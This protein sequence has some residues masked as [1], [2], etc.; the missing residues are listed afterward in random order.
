MVVLTKDI[1]REFSNHF[2]DHMKGEDFMFFFYDLFTIGSAYIV[3]GYFR[4]FL[5]KQHSRDID[6]ITDIADEQLIDIL[7]SSGGRYIKN[8]HGGIKILL[9]NTEIDIWTLDN[10][11]A[12]KNNLV[13]LN[14]KDKVN[15]I[16]KGCFYNF[17]A[18]VF[19][20]HNH[21]YSLRYFSA[22]LETKE[23][24]ILQE[25]P[26]YKVLNTSTEAN[27]LRAFY[28]NKKF[29][30]T[31]SDNTKNYLAMKL[32]YLEDLYQNNTWHL[33]NNIQKYPKYS[34]LTENDLKFYIASL[35]KNSLL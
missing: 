14:E 26:L 15:S 8:R 20:L 3:G 4:D 11:W 18:L 16:A 32:G 5:Q 9:K 2:T 12:F 34:L 29:G 1:K 27:L 31:F 19:N 25:N 21:N 33:L 24:D 35:R 7:K 10:N 6:I 30:L 17:D 22:C 28:L 13:K 23:L